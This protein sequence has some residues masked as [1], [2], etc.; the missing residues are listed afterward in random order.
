MK[1]AIITSIKPDKKNTGG[2]SGLIWEIQEYLS[3][4]KKLQID[5]Y[6]IKNSK[7]KY[8]KQINSFGIYAMKYNE[9]NLERYEKILLYPDFLLG[10]MSPK[11]YKKIIVLAPDA[12]SM[13]G[14]RKYRIYKKDFNVS[15]I[16]KIY[17]YIYY[18]R[19]ICFEKKYIPQIN[20]YIVV[21]KNDRLWLKNHVENKYKDKIIFLR[22]PLLSYSMA[23]LENINISIF[24]EKRY[25]FSGDMRY[26]YVGKNIEVL[27]KKLSALLE[28][29]KKKVSIVVVGKNNKWIASLFKNQNN[30]D[31][32]YYSWIERYQDICQIGRDIHCIPLAAGGGTKNRVLT[33]IANG[34]EVIS[35]FIGIENIPIKGMS[36]IYVYNNMEDFSKCMVRLSDKNINYQDINNLIKERLIFRKRI[37]NEFKQKINS[38]F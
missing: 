33:A 30:I 26:S 9:K 27:A 11:L 1:I 36:G 5:T 32:K 7:N 10:Y 35:T 38:I 17:Q 34:L 4:E 15:F 23:K 19:F 2:P 12:S 3:K 16:K 21:G 24:K 25:I 14:K 29:R 28:C 18:K 8:L 37:T 31:V 6:I 22:H 20:K 13:V